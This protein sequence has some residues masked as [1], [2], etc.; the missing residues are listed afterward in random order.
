MATVGDAATRRLVVT[1]A[2]TAIALG[3]GDVPVLATPRI[4]AL[5]EEA[6]AAAVANSIGSDSTTVGTNVNLDHTAP[7]PVGA[8]VEATAE[9]TAVEGR[10]ITFAVAVH[11]DG[12]PVASG[13]HTRA[14]VDRQRFLDSLG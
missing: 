12:E 4:V 10:T 3:S 11:Q 9:V 1:D 14:I 13:Q 8:S 6:A 2:D 7:T 5:C